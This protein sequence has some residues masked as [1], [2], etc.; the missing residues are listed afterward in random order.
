MLDRLAD[1]HEQLQPLAGRQVL[2]VAEP[3]DG[4]AL[5]QLHDEVRPAGFGRAGVEHAGNVLMVHQRQR[6]PLG[7]EAGD[8]LPAVHAGLDDLQGD[9]AADGLFLLGHVDDAH[10]ALAD[11]LEQLVRADAVAGAFR[12]AGR[13]GRIDPPAR[14]HIAGGTFGSGG[15]FQEAA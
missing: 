12:E 8:D 4:D 5:D 10:A 3:G 6:L 14:G 15:L 1:G 13:I 7:L 9:L 11:L 2:L